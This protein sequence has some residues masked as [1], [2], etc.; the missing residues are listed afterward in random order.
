M[1]I[2]PDLMKSILAMDSYNRGY[3]PR[4]DLNIRDAALTQ[5]VTVRSASQTSQS[6]QTATNEHSINK[7]AN[8]T[9]VLYDIESITLTPGNDTVTLSRNMFGKIANDNRQ[10]VP[11]AL[12]A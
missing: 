10:L 9:D 7:G 8:G 4:I 3:L 5:G 12:T 1:T 11:L 6:Y 2:N